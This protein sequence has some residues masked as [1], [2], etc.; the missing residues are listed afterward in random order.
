[1]SSFPA[2]AAARV[3]R[4]ALKAP[5]ASPLVLLVRDEQIVVPPSAHILQGFRDWVLSDAVPEKLKI[6]FIDGEIIIDM[7]GEELETH[8]KVKGEMNSVL[9]HLN[10]KTKG[11]EY[12]DDC[13]QFSNEAANLSVIPDG[14]FVSWESFESGKVKLVERIGEEGQ[15]VELEGSPDMVLEIVSKYSVRKDT[16]R[17]RERFAKAGIREYWLIDARGEDIDFQILVRE[18]GEPGASASGYRPAVR[19]KGWQ[20]SPVFG[21]WFRLV[22]RRGRLGRWEYTL[23]VKTAGPR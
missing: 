13:S 12:Y 2:P 15:Y 8:G 14:L 20:Y 9:T 11:G 6:H 16:V 4:K 18:Q 10:K 22:R 5:P 7:S 21:R 23:Q 1:M 19:K 17:L 3:A